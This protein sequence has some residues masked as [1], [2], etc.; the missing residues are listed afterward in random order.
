MLERKRAALEEQTQ[1]LEHYR[2]VQRQVRSTHDERWSAAVSTLVSEHVCA[3]QLDA[4]GRLIRSVPDS[5][6]S[7]ARGASGGCFG[8]SRLR[9]NVVAL[10]IHGLPLDPGPQ[11]SFAG[12]DDDEISSALGCTAAVLGERIICSLQFYCA[13]NIE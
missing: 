8:Y 2:A 10:K 12:C 6:H 11:G 5:S 9:L 4:R 3:V 13:E 1:G 7:G